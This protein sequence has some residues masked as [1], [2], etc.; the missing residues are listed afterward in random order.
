MGETLFEKI[1]AVNLLNLAKYLDLQVHE[2]NMSYVYSNI[3]LSSLRHII[4]KQP[5]IKNKERILKAQRE[6]SYI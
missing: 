6:I 4:T 2:A 1:I 5:E 3:K